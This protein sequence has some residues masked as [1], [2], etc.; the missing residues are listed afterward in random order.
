MRITKTRN[1][2][3]TLA[4]TL[5]F[6]TVLLVPLMPTTASADNHGSS[7]TVSLNATGNATPIG[8]GDN[9]RNGNSNGGNNGRTSGS[10]STAT[11]A[12]AGSAYSEGNGNQIKLLNLTGSLQI[13][14]TTYT[15][16]KGHGDENSNGTL[17]IQAKSNNGG[18]DLELELHGSVQG[19]NVVFNSKESKLASSYFLS[20]SGQESLTLTTSSST[21][22]SITNSECTG[23]GDEECANEISTSTVTVTVPQTLTETTNNTITVT[24]TNNQ[25]V[26]QTIG[27]PTA[28]QTVTVTQP[29]AT[30]VTETNNQTVT[31]TQTIT[32]AN[33]TITVTAT[34]TVANT[35]I[36]VTTT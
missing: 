11:L 18:H 27:S 22:S 19:N 29:G 32:S 2:R 14:S 25:T 10:P 9:K 34:T 26:T 12:L 30:T 24:Q 35:T 31:Q 23:H 7:G 17:E 13:G 36:T 6:L 3:I 5:V 21:S 8:N 4:L 16:S 1:H 15:L 28:T 20:L 33:T